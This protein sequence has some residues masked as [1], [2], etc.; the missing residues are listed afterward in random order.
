MGQL[1]SLC[2][3]D[4]F[5][6]LQ[7]KY[8][9]TFAKVMVA[10]KSKD[11]VNEEFGKINGQANEK[12]QGFNNQTVS[13]V[14]EKTKALSSLFEE[15]KGSVN[16]KVPG[17]IPALERL[18]GQSIND[19]SGFNSLQG[20]IDSVKTQAFQKIEAE[21]S[22]VMGELNSKKVGMIAQI[23]KEKPRIEMYDDL[24]DPIKSVV[25]S[26]AEETFADQISKNKGA[27]VDSI[28]KQFN[29]NNLDSLFQK[30]SPESTLNGIVGSASSKLTSALGLG[31]IGNLIGGGSGGL[32]NML[33]GSGIPFFK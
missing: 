26:K 7:E 28:A 29:I 31:G 4:V 25:R 15:L 13:L 9:E 20:Q 32:G 11:I 30:I 12:F 6:E 3:G 16:S 27:I 1:T 23:D 5:K 17:G 14:D 19:F 22:N 18:K 24:P 33:G 2:S 21:K 10:E 8:G